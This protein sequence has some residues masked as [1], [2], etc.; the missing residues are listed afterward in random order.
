[1]YRGEL[2]AA[3]DVGTRAVELH[4]YLQI[5][6]VNYALAL[7]CSGRL[8]DALRQYQIASVTSPDLPWLR[9]LEGRCL[10][11]MGRVAQATT[12]LEE[13]EELRRSEY[14]D[15]YHMA[16]FRQ[17]LGQAEE[18]WS[19]LE[20]SV[21]EKSGFSLLMQVDPKAEAFKRDPR[22]AA[23]SPVESPSRP[24]SQTAHAARP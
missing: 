21:E 22:F 18:A 24:S 20:R 4:P 23:L 16:V 9:A 3:I 12:I 7:E 17:A 19:E 15:A 8:D 2:D 13:L 5:V 14:V 6:R 11:R 1:M 10:A